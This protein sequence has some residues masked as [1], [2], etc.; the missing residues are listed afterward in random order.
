MYVFTFFWS[1]TL[2]SARADQ[3]STLAFGI[4][5]TCFMDAMMLGATLFNEVLLN[6]KRIT[7]S[8]VSRQ[9]G[10][11]REHMTAVNGFTTIWRALES[12]ESR[13]RDPR[14]NTENDSSLVLN[15]QPWEF[16]PNNAR[17][18]GF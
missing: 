8:E 5:I 7:S 3:R 1:P 10:R 2:Q 11:R 17:S 14:Y 15:L 18:Y 16:S 13:I 6:K 4:I 12:Y 9:S